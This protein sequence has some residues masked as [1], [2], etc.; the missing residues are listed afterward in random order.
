MEELLLTAEELQTSEELDSGIAPLDEDSSEDEE[1]LPS[2]LEEASRL[3]LE[4]SST[5]VL[6]ELSSE[7]ATRKAKIVMDKYL[8]NVRIRSP[9]SRNIYLLKGKSLL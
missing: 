1:S 9:Y 6:E 3:S 4:R 7:Q 5:F 2:E 8:S